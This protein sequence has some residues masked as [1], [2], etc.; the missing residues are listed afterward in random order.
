M[1]VV[2]ITMK[3][4]LLPL[5]FA[6]VEGENNDSWSWFLTLV[7]KEVLGP[8]RSICIISDCH[9]GLLNG[10]KNIFKATL[11]LYT[12]GV[13]VILPQTFRRSN[14]ARKLLKG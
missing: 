6:L 13:H 3:N 14:G 1:V 2:G 9:R 5:A 7:R 8:S 12:D 4:H 11:P 10:A